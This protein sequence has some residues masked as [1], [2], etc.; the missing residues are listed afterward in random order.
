M[1]NK[2]IFIAIFMLIQLFHY[3]QST[4]IKQPEITTTT[5][6][7]CGSQCHYGF[8]A[9]FIGDYPLYKG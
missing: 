4:C 9:A 8:T 2:P 7:N 5:G 3:S 6:N 1:N